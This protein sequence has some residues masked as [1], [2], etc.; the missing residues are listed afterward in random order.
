MENF[1]PTNADKLIIG[2]FPTAKQ[3]RSFEF[4]YPNKNNPFWKV[5]ASIA[6]MTLAPADSSKAIQNRKEVL[7][8]LNL[9]ITD[10]K[11]IVMRIVH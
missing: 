9:G 2:T 3:R 4:F 6:E 1:I 11:F 5:L 8:K 10:I 7:T